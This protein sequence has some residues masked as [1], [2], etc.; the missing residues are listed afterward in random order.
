MSL[1]R[2]ATIYKAT[3]PPVI[4]LLHTH[5]KEKAFTPPGTFQLRS[6]GFVQPDEEASD[7]LVVPFPGGLA[8]SVRIDDKVLPVAVVKARAAERVKQIEADEGI[9]VGKKRRKQILEEVRDELAATALV[10]TTAIITCYYHEASGYLIVPTTSKALCDVCLSLLVQAVGSVKTETIHVS[11]IKHGLTTRLKNYIAYE[12]GEH[13]DGEDFGAFR[14]CDDA[15]MV[16]SE[17]R[18]VT[19]RMGYLVGAH[20]AIS[21]ALKKGFEV[22]SLGF[23]FD[24]KVT[25]R[26]GHDFKLRSVVYADAPES[27]EDAPWW[28]LMAQYQVGNVVSVVQHLVELLSYKEPGSEAQEGQAAA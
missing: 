23:N 16:D 1:I 15:A 10:K 5:L 3:I 9:K 12:T 22:T 2:A 18:R 28:P 20:E 19:V 27:P 24:D 6:A 11:N 26:L 21:E 4:D 7:S 14:P 13:D 25:F 17:K 8:F